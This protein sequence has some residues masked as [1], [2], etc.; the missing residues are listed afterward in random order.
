[1]INKTLYARE[2]KNS[3]KLL[4]ILAAV[5]ALYIGIIIYM[6]EPEMMALLDSYVDTM[7]EMMAAVGMTAGATDLLGFMIS[8]LYGFILLVF[9]MIFCILRADRL[10]ARYTTSGAMSYLLAA[11]VSRQ[12][13]VTTQIAALI[14]GTILLI[15]FATALEILVAEH[16]PQAISTSQTCSLS[17]PVSSACSFSSQA[18]ASFS[19]QPARTASSVSVSAPAFPPSRSSCKCSPTPAIRQPI[20]NTPPFSPSS[21]PPDSPLATFPHCSHPARCFSPPSSVSSSLGLFSAAKACRSK[22]NA[23]ITF[24]GRGAV[25]FSRAMLY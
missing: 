25:H 8:Y 4:F 13:I 1:M 5:M 24:C 2:M 14:S 18:S 15:L 10:L 16:F 21:I 23:A 3:V 7:P 19:P 12:R 20:S 6:Y 17:T 9:P 11:P 22:T